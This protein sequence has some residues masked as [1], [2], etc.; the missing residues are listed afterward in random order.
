MTETQTRPAG[1]A[2][3]PPEPTGPDL[4]RLGWRGTLRFVWA[5]LTSMRTAL[6]LLF[7]LAVAAGAARAW[8]KPDEQLWLA[9]V[10]A[11]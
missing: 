9:G 7:A 1:H 8:I 6:V 10:A 3:E 2:D 11:H 5:Q 4:P